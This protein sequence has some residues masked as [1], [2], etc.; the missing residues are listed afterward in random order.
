[1]PEASDTQRD[2][3]L[4]MTEHVHGARPKWNRAGRPSVVPDQ[5]GALDIEVIGGI[6][7]WN[8][9][10]RGAPT[11]SADHARGGSGNATKE[12]S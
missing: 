9:E 6:V 1:M 7:G 12:G 11:G 2:E 3:W 10:H 8:M 5:T 4:L